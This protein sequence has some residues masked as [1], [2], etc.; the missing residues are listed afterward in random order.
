MHGVIVYDNDQLI[1][2]GTSYTSLPTTYTYGLVLMRG[3]GD[4]AKDGQIDISSMF[5][6]F[7]AAYHLRQLNAASEVDNL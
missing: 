3:T 2:N 5:V 4:L 7:D 6:T 1:D